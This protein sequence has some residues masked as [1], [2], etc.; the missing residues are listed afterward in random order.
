LPC[1]MTI[2]WCSKPGLLWQTTIMLKLQCH[3]H[4]QENLHTGQIFGP[5]RAVT[6]FINDSAFN[7]C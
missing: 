3:H 1:K 7:F 2:P 5:K 6:I 4:S